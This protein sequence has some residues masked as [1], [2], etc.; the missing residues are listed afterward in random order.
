MTA[1]LI[2]P[3]GKPVGVWAPPVGLPHRGESLGVSTGN[4]N[5]P[6]PTG[7]T[8][9]HHSCATNYRKIM[10]VSGP[11]DPVEVVMTFESSVVP[12]GSTALI[13]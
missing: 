4:P 9:R 10:I 3:R 1:K 12:S 11:I 5:P 6:S 13:R 8:N 2:H 7:H